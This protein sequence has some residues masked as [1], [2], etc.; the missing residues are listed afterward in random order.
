MMNKCL[1]M[2]VYNLSRRDIRLVEKA[3]FIFF[4]PVGTAGVQQKNYKTTIQ[5]KLN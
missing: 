3:S 1:K 5:K 4:R 2:Q